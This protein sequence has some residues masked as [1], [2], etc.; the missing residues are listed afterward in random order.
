MSASGGS[1]NLLGMSELEIV[2]EFRA[3]LETMI[4]RTTSG[5]I[6][7]DGRPRRLHGEGD[8]PK[9]ENISYRLYADYIPTGVFEDHK[10]GVRGK[11]VASAKGRALPEYTA[12]ERADSEARYAAERAKREAEDRAWRA[13]AQKQ[14]QL[15]WASSSERVDPR[16]SYLEKKGI[17]GVGDIRQFGEQLRVPVMD[18]EDVIGELINGGSGEFRLRGFQRIWPDGD[19]RFVAGTEVHG[20]CFAIGRSVSADDVVY[21]GEGYATC[22]SVHLAIQGC[23]IVA[24]SCGNLLAVGRLVRARRPA[25][26]I[27]FL[28][29]D[30]RKKPAN[31]GR[32]AATKAAHVVNGIVLLPPFSDAEVEAGLSDWNDYA[33][34]NGADA[35][36]AAV[37]A[38]LS[39]AVRP[40]SADSA[41]NAESNVSVAATPMMQSSEVVTAAETETADDETNLAIG[42]TI[43]PLDTVFAGPVGE[44]AVTLAPETEAAVV[45]ILCVL[46]V[47]FGNLIGRSAHQMIDGVRHAGNLFLAL[48]GLSGSGR[49]GTTVARARAVAAAIDP[50]Y[51]RVNIVSGLSSGQGLVARVRDAAE[52]E[53]E[54]DDFAISPTAVVDKRLLVSEPEFSSALKQMQLPG[55]VLSQVLRDAWDS[56]PL[57]FLTKRSPMRATDPHISLVCQTTPSELRSL[58]KEIDFHNGLLNRFLWIHV[59]RSQLLPHGEGGIPRQASAAIARMRDNATWA[60]TVEGVQMDALARTWWEDHYLVLSTGSPG[61]AG[62]LTRRAAAHVRR[63]AMLYALTERRAVI[64]MRDLEA[65]LALWTYSVASAEHIFGGADGFSNLARRL[66]A[67]IES[68]GEAGLS[69]TELWSAAGTNNIT[70]EQIRAAVGQLVEA[71]RVFSDVEQ[72]RGRPRHVWKSVRFLKYSSNVSASWM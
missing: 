57:Q 20:G 55:N 47:L 18:A 26:R 14:F 29:D 54:D 37:T 63:L 31:P 8:R 21:I 28:A 61:R 22:A 66:L 24:F 9:R 15:E 50:E 64:Q 45:G 13:D 38:A 25:A 71:G 51:C 58:V 1:L 3:E 42:G 72:T 23:V 19:K 35:V 60:R 4:G 11:W 6:V 59:E 68:A 2:R 56:N 33:L 34:Q 69:Q 5:E 48:V 10:L 41:H 12:A 7:P 36:R 52:E 39:E 70:S 62:S 16:H 53:G 40:S 17:S 44:I 46:L 49:K 67:A 32:T 27:V 30:D 65:A 43:K